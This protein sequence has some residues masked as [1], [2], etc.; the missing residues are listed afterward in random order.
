MICYFLFWKRQHFPLLIRLF[1]QFKGIPEVAETPVR[2]PQTTQQPQQSQQQQPSQPSQPSQPQ[3]STTP[4][5]NMF[6]PQPT[7][8]SQ[9]SRKFFC[10]QRILH[11]TKQ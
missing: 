11:S 4:F 10:F 6:A 8:Q 1:F 3:T 7:Q 5:P 9:Q 2:S